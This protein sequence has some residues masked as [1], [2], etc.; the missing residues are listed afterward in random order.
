MFDIYLEEVD[1]GQFF[2]VFVLGY[3][4]VQCVSLQTFRLG[5]RIACGVR[6]FGLVSGCLLKQF[7]FLLNYDMCIVG[8]LGG[9]EFAK[10][11]IVVQ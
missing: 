6:V 8:H 7:C 4:L 10:G 5:K 11:S 1:F 9:S 3:V 2:R